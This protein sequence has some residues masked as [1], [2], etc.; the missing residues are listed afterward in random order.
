M[1][2]ISG[3][4]KEELLSS[5]SK[6]R[7]EMIKVASSLGI[8]SRETIMQSKELDLLINMYQRQMLNL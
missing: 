1:I 7:A 5:I 8:K 4:R 2:Q 6:K 3:T